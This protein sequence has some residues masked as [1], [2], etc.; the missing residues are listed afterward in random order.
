M[1]PLQLFGGKW[2]SLL[3]LVVLVGE[4]TQQGM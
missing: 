3:N 4:V 1:V 2:E